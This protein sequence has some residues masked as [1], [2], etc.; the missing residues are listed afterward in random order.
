[1]IPVNRGLFKQIYRQPPGCILPP[2][3][4]RHYSL[5]AIATL[6]AKMLQPDRW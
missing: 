4:S 6:P 1:L 5:I 3:F 2:S